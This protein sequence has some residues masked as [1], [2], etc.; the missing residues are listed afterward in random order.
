MR[1]VLE[2]ETLA[3][4]LRKIKEMRG[5]TAGFPPGSDL[6][7]ED[8]RLERE[9]SWPRT[10]IDAIDDQVRAG[11]LL[12]HPIH[13]Q[14]SGI[15]SNGGDSRRMCG[16]RADVCV[17]AV[18]WGEVASNLRKRMGVSHESRILSELLPSEAEIVAVRAEDAVRAGDLRVDKKLAYADAFAVD[19][20]MQ[21]RA[22]ILVTADYDFKAVEDLARIE[23]LPAKI[24][25]QLAMIYCPPQ[26]AQSCSMNV[27]V[28]PQCKS[29]T[30]RASPS[31]G[32]CAWWSLGSRLGSAMMLPN[33]FLPRGPHGVSSS[34]PVSYRAAGTRSSLRSW[35]VSSI[36]GLSEAMRPGHC[37]C[38]PAWLLPEPQRASALR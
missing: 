20:A 21:S 15:R 8:R 30:V 1:V 29:A 23:F 6:L 11:L 31:E 24:R 34:I 18:Q 38:R 28:I 17:S 5:C 9:R 13:R 37:E 2:P 22:N 4:K 7:L 33:S 12:S 19:L 10:A 14:R 36:A 35:R 25:N 32:I 27:S 26:R 3:L 16:C